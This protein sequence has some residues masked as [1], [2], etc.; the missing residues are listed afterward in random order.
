[1]YAS[2]PIKYHTWSNWDSSSC[3]YGEGKLTTPFGHVAAAPTASL[4]LYLVRFHWSLL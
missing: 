2:T 1:M 3:A 4:P